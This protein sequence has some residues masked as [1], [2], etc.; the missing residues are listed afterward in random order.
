MTADECIE[1]IFSG[2]DGWR[3][4]KGTPKTQRHGSLP[5]GDDDGGQESANASADEGG[6]HGGTLR[7]SDMHRF[8]QH[9]SSSHRHLLGRSP[10]SSRPR[11]HHRRNISAA[12][13]K[14]G[15]TVTGRD[16]AAGHGQV[17]PVPA[18][19]GGG[20]GSAGRRGHGKEDELVA[21]GSGTSSSGSR[22]RSQSVASL[23]PTLGS[24]SD[25]DTRGRE[26]GF[27]RAKEV[28]E[29][30]MRDDMVAWRLPGA[31]VSQR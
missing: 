6:R 31:A 3:R 23:A 20:G 18:G 4:V 24:G 13:D 1:N 9:G 21:H 10:S 30:E 15:V 28:D 7:P 17:A 29:F 11:W 5:D 26:N 25:R 14:S 16:E 27:R 22:S 2:G 8:F 19:G 12:S